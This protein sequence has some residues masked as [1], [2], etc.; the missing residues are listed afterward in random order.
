MKLFFTFF[1]IL[2]SIAPAAIGASARTASAEINVAEKK[3]AAAVTRVENLEKQRN[4]A[5]LNGGLK[6]FLSKLP[7]QNNPSLDVTNV[8]QDPDT[9][10][11]R[12][13]ITWVLLWS[14]RGYMKYQKNHVLPFYKA[15]LDQ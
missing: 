11:K 10:P 8:D 5:V 7:L 15:H 12:G 13:K 4:D 3:L 2:S 14:G 9:T 1:V 6:T